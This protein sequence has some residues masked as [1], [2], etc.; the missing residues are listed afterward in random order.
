MPRISFLEATRQTGQLV[1][2]AEQGLRLRSL[3]RKN[4]SEIDPR[5]A[6]SFSKKGAA[7]AFRLLQK[8]W[9]LVLGIESLDPWLTGQVL[10]EV[11]LRE[12]QTRN[13]VV[14]SLAIKMQPS[15]MFSSGFP[16]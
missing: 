9:E 12:G 8:D 2:R 1:V 6:G 5:T 15:E 3:T 14:A 7:L 13:L 10:Q 4:V 11:T 16:T